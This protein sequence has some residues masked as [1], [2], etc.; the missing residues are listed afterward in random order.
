VVQETGEA[1][2]HS[3]GLDHHLDPPVRVVVPAV[4]PAPPGSQR[5]DAQRPTCVREHRRIGVPEKD[6]ERPKGG[7]D[8][9]R[10]GYL[11]LPGKEDAQRSGQG[12]DLGEEVVLARGQ[13]VEKLRERP[14]VQRPRTVRGAVARDAHE[15]RQQRQ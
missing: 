3:R 1:A 5:Q 11:S 4:I 15:Y 9:P 6:A 2:A 10:T 7:R 12:A 13:A 8:P 14:R